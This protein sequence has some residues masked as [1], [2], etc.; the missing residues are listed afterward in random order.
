MEAGL[1]RG[2][3]DI[4]HLEDEDKRK[5]E[6]SRIQDRDG[7][8]EKSASALFTSIRE[9]RQVPLDRFIFALGI[10]HI[11]L[12]TAQAIAKHFGEPSAW[13][14]GMMSLSQDDQG[15][16]GQ[17]ERTTTTTTTNAF[18]GIEGIGPIILQA[19]Q[20]YIMDDRNR[21]LVQ[22]LISELEVLPMTTAASGQLL[23]T[24]GAEGTKTAK[25]ANKTVLFT[26]TL[27]KMTRSQAEALVVSLGGTPTKTVSKK[28]DLVVMGDS[29][30]SK[31]RKAETLGLQ[32][33]D[34]E[35]F[36]EFV[37]NHDDPPPSPPLVTQ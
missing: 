3:L 10:P 32:I 19:L 16:E 5:E 28:V 26:G 1:I 35:S 12:T 25:L 15:K 33:M 14:A 17:E 22:G 24:P 36:L 11:G 18:S 34:E 30:G 7:W 8:G 6:G 4:F 27:S 21:A 31:A 2:P 37:N 13:L 29:P 20:D 9:Q 23:I